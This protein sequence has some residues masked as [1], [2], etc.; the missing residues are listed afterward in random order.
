MSKTSF[1]VLTKA[2]SKFGNR[3]TEKDYQS[4]LACQSVGEIMS[5]LKNNTHYS[6][7]LTDVS[8]RE[9]HRGRLEALLRQNLFF[10]QIRF[11]RKLGFVIVHYLDIRG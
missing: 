1:A 11:E 5:Y 6:K 4:L 2:R 9:I 3:L 7:A 10:V 8:E